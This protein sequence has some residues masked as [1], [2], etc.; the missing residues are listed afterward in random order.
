MRKLV[1]ILKVY[2]EKIY[3]VFKYLSVFQMIL[4][5]YFLPD[6]QSTWL[7]VLLTEVKNADEET[8]LDL[9]SCGPDF[10]YFAYGE[11]FVTLNVSL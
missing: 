5:E 3:R 6:Y 2:P 7:V 1:K 11:D 10:N 4:K 9:L 8:I